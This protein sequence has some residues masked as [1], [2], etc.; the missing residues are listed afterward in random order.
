VVGLSVGVALGTLVALALGVTLGVG[1]G[2]LVAV[3]VGVGLAL[4]AAVD[5]DVGAG[6]G[7][8]ASS[9]QA[10]RPASARS[11]ND[12]ETAAMRDMVSPLFCD[13]TSLALGGAA[14]AQRTAGGCRPYETIFGINVA[15]RRGDTRCRRGGSTC[16]NG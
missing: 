8:C 10:A 12:R 3:A 14:P 11:S 5:V 13:Y 4:G 7:V 2:M 6:R 9:P 16:G 15:H 1:L